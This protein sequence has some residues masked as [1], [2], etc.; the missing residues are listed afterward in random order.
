MSKGKNKENPNHLK[1][2]E[3]S[4]R[5]EEE[6][7]D[8]GDILHDIINAGEDESKSFYQITYS[9]KGLVIAWDEKEDRLLAHCHNLTNMELNFLLQRMIINVHIDLS[10][11]ELE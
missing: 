9:K 8:F 2:L 3:F 7:D 6:D 11:A 4:P 10:G 1:V 5:E